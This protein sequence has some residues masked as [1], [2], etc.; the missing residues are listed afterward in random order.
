MP[1][2][3]LVSMTLALLAGCFL[4]LLFARPATTLP[5]DFEDNLVIDVSAPIALAF[6]PD[7]RLLVTSKMGE[8]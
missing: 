3:T 8:L 5:N 6:L 4:C 2:R 1:G 7:G